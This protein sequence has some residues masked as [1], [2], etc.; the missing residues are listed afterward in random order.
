MRGND[1]AK[2]DFDPVDFF[3]LVGS[4]AAKYRQHK[5][6]DPVLAFQ[7]SPDSIDLAYDRRRVYNRLFYIVSIAEKEEIICV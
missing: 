5:Y 1:E 2:I 3:N 4:N 7:Y 6:P